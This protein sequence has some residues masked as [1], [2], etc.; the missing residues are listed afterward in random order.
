MYYICTKIVQLDLALI[1]LSSAEF[2]VFKM[3]II[4]HINEVIKLML[5]VLMMSKIVGKPHNSHVL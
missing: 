3:C 4:I 5:V 1:L 2:F